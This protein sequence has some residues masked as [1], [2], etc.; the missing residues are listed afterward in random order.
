MGAKKITTRTLET[1][2]QVY[3]HP[4]N[5][6]FPDGRE[7]L[8]PTRTIAD[9]LAARQEEFEEA[10]KARQERL[11]QEIAAK[12]ESLAAHPAVPADKTVL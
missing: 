6:E 12:R 5:D 4:A 2:E 10:E 1:G 3:H 11:L 9:R 8:V 7:V